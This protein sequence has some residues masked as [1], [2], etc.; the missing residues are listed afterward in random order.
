M[1]RHE[2]SETF[3][4]AGRLLCSRLKAHEPHTGTTS[5]AVQALAAHRTPKQKWAMATRSFSLAP[6]VS[7]SLLSHQACLLGEYMHDLP[8]PPTVRWPRA[9]SPLRS[10]SA[11]AR[12]PASR[13]RRAWTVWCHGC[14]QRVRQPQP[15]SNKGEAVHVG[16]CGRS[17][18][19]GIAV[20]RST[21]LC[22]SD[23]GHD[24]Y[25]HALPCPMPLVALLG[26][27]PLAPRA[28]LSP[29]RVSGV[30]WLQ[31]DVHAPSPVEPTGPRRQCCNRWCR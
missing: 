27:H 15:A 23:G 28:L 1:A 17:S 5:H 29:G 20:L 7:Q 24:A 10:A 14:G 13:S 22:R 11:R 25:P 6:S 19:P 2:A 18:E 9:A 16:F 26:R 4:H 31:G 8:R 3:G 12:P 21:V 30:P